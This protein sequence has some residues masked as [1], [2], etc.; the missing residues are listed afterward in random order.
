M[1]TGE[2]RAD[3]ELLPIKFGPVSNGEFHPQPHSPRLKEVIRRTHRLA[4]EKARRLGMSRRQFLNSVRGAA[5]TLF[6]LGA[7]SKE[8]SNSRGERPGGSFDVSEDATEDT[9]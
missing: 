7:C 8:E 4:D 1:G 5:A 2:Y 6:V 3:P 9:D